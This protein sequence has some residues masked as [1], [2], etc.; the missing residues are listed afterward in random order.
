MKDYVYQN[1][2]VKHSVH[3]NSGI[4]RMFSKEGHVKTVAFCTKDKV[5]CAETYNDAALMW[6]ADGQKRLEEVRNQIK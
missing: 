4:C 1:D 2:A 6:I 3:C 5:Y